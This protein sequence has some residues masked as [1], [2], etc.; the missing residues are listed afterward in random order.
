VTPAGESVLVDAGNPGARDPGRIA[1][2]AKE[3]ARLKRLDYIVVTHL[4]TDHFG[5]VADLASLIPIGTLYDSGV[6]NA[7]ETERAQTTVPAYRAAA[8]GKRLVIKAGDVI[9]LKNQPGAGLTRLAV[10]AARQTISTTT[11]GRPNAANCANLSEK[12]V[13]TS[14]NANSV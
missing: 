8:V 4:H 5:G 11:A 6:D 3:T 13:D 9:P 2:T 1:K 10:L 7:P 12:P 14:D